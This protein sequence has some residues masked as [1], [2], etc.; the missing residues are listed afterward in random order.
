MQLSLNHAIPSADESPNSSLA[1]QVVGMPISGAVTLWAAA[2]LRTVHLYYMHGLK[3]N[4]VCPLC[5]PPPD[6]SGTSAALRSV[7]LLPEASL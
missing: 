1:S 4:V 5:R 7:L 6:W 2:R 3:T